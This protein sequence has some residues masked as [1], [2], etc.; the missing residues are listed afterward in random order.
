MTDNQIVEAMAGVDGYE[1][2]QCLLWGKYRQPKW[3]VWE[4]GGRNWLSCPDYLNSHDAVQRVVGVLGVLELNDVEHNMYE[5]S[6][7]PGFLA[8][9]PRQKCEAILKAKGLWEEGE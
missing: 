2:V 5:L 4:Y 3:K 7:R 6:G 9:T 1:D 8:C